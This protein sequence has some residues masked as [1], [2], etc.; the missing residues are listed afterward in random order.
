MNSSYYEV[1]SLTIFLNQR[2]H[3]IYN[4]TRMFACQ[5][6][7]RD[8]IDKQSMNLV[9][10]KSTHLLASQ[11]RNFIVF[12]ANHIHER[13]LH[14]VCHASQSAA[15]Q[16]IQCAQACIRTQIAIVFREQFLTFGNTQER[17][18]DQKEEIKNKQLL[19][20]SQSPLLF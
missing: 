9:Y 17:A 18:F 11:L 19:K 2:L 15:L 3:R 8:G 12:G 1:N 16:V 4:H 5:H 13:L 7:A 14:T 10:Y 20:M 6:Y